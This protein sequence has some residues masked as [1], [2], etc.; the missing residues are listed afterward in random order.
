MCGSE[1]QKAMIADICNGKLSN[2]GMNHT[3]AGVRASSFLVSVGAPKPKTRKTE[4][5][6]SIQ[7]TS[8]PELKHSIFQ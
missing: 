2:M 7:G 6:G 1:A 3:S 5:E 4:E 8:L